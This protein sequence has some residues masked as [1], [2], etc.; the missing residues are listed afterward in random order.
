[1]PDLSFLKTDHVTVAGEFP[2]AQRTFRLKARHTK[3][4]M[5][6]SNPAIGMVKFAKCFVV[7]HFNI[8][9]LVVQQFFFEI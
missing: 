1:M 2:V 7:Y 5:L 8:Y 9:D 6:R 3:K 4:R